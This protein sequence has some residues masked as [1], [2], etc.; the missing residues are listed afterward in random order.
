MGEVKNIGIS[1]MEDSEN[2]IGKEKMIYDN[3]S[4]K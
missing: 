1:D 3:M 2:N 4:K